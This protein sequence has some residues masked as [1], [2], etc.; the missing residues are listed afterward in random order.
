M[1]R[2]KIYT[3]IYNSNYLNIQ[4]SV[5]GGGS[6]LNTT[7]NIRK[8]LPILFEKF[9]IESVLDIPCGDFNWMKQVIKNPIQYIGADIVDELVEDNNLHYS[10][11][12]CIEFK[13]LD[14]VEDELP[15]VDLIIVKDLFI[16]FSIGDIQKSIGNIKKSG[17]KYVLITNGTDLVKTNAEIQTDGGYRGLNMSLDPFNFPESIY[18][19]ETLV[20]NSKLSMWEINKL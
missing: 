7:E 5:S 16:H 3:D 19:I 13:V 2:K 17:S 6:E 10:I 18:E 4:E 1:N 12:N 15:K 20:C 11:P 8:E 9:K 14:I